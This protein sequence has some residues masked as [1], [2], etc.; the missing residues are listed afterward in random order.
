MEDGRGEEG[1]EREG[2]G[3]HVLHFDFLKAR[4][5]E[6]YKK[7]V[8]ESEQMMDQK[9]EEMEEERAQWEGKLKKI[10]NEREG[11]I[12]IFILSSPQKT[13]QT[14]QGSTRNRYLAA[15]TS[16][17]GRKSETGGVADAKPEV[18]EGCARRGEESW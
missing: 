12:L 8:R 3:V 15:K 5:E 4:Q 17:D 16:I 1:G 7:R 2:R 10:V 6:E 13:K 18:T 9:A 14:R 11:D